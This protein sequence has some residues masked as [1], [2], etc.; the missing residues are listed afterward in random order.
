MSALT[1]A[2]TLAGE[3][4]AMA[5]GW[6]E[7]RLLNHA[8]ERLGRAVGQFFPH[9][10]TAV[11]YLGKG[12]NAGDTLVALRILRDEFHW[13]IAA[14]LAYPLADCAPLTRKKWQETGIDHS[15]P[16]PPVWQDCKRPILLLDGLLGSG[17]R[18]EL[19][20][21]LLQLAQEMSALRLHAGARV[22]AVD[23]PSGIDPDSGRIFPHTVVADVTFMMGNAKLGLLTGQAAPATGA[24]AVVPVEPLTVTRAGPI[25]VISPQTLDFAKAPRPFDFHKGMAGRV[26]IVAGSQ[27]YTGAAVIAAS[28]ALRG[29]GG[30]VTLF[31]PPAVRPMIASSCPPEVIVRE[32]ENPS[33]VLK[34]RYDSLV[35][36]CGL[37]EI[38][39]KTE[40]GW[41]ELILNSAVPTVVDADALTLLARTGS[42]GALSTR[43]VLTP[44]PGEFARLAPDFVDLPREEAARRFTDERCAAVLLLKGCRTL[45]TCR[46]AALWCNSTGTPGMATGGQGD[47]LAGVIGARLANGDST[48][49][50]AALSA[51]LC[52]RAAE[53]AM[54]TPN[55]SEESLLPSD[56]LT[57]LGGA[58]QGWKSASR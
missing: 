2:E 49:E 35:I 53:I 54:Q 58:F 26:A 48:M 47:L 56:I 9:P 10:G 55:T 32:I 29:G 37:G 20:E 36:G 19:R 22:A 41:M 27:T 11:G 28:G 16:H 23:I 52:G 34:F 18:G 13:S 33:D 7:E 25:D 38:D 21:P 50:A 43:H 30:L 51:W 24:L 14:R 44:H 3:A 12:H 15:L 17:S 31:V 57:H 40:T 46:N 1:I 39:P 45:V 5:S 8:G 4:V 42:L 6:T